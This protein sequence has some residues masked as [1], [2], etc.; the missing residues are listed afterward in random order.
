MAPS[1][2]HELVLLE[3]FDRQDITPVPFD[4]EPVTKD[5]Y[6]KLGQGGATIAAGNYEGVLEDRLRLL[7]EPT[8][9]GFRW[10]PDIA[11]RLNKGS[12][13]SFNDHDEKSQVLA[14]GRQRSMG[15]K[16]SQVSVKTRTAIFDKLVRGTYTPLN[17]AAHKQPVLNDI[18]R[19]TLRNSTY[20]EQ[21][22]TKLLK[23]IR[24]LLPS[25]TAASAKS[26]QQK[27]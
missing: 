4:P 20:L 1:T 13:V 17:A 24:S 22:Q 23:K 19:N 27:N 2:Q 12:F 21:D 9:D 5:H 14:A 10:A 15:A 8:Q 16:F 7:A 11:S 18:I 26:S 25:E 6:L 3:Q